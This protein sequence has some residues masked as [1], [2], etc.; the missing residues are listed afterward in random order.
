M[1]IVVV[2]CYGVVVFVNFVVVVDADVSI[3]P[4]T[5]ATT[6]PEHVGFGSTSDV[7]LQEKVA[8]D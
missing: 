4:P 2:D 8:E 5:A 3:Q 6:D 7:R 1:L